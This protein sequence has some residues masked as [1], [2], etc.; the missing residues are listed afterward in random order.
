MFIIKIIIYFFRVI[1]FRCHAVWLLCSKSQT[2]KLRTAKL[3]S[4]MI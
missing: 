4:N 1:K 2:A 3:M